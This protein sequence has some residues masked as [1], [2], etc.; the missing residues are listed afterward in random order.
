MTLQVIDNLDDTL[1]TSCRVSMLSSLVCLGNIFVIHTF[2]IF[3][4]LQGREK[5][6]LSK[7]AI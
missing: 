3:L 6:K 7:K 4:L 5:R 2:Y 1:Q